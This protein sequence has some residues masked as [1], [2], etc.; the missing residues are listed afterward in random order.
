[1]DKKGGGGNTKKPPNA[2]NSKQGKNQTK[3][4]QNLDIR[5]HTQ[6]SKNDQ[7]WS[8]A[9]ETAW[10]L[11]ATH[12]HDSC[13]LKFIK[14]R[15]AKIAGLLLLLVEL[16]II[17]LTLPVLQL[18]YWSFSKSSFL[19]LVLYQHHS[20]IFSPLIRFLIQF[21]ETEV[22]SKT[23]VSYEKAFSLKG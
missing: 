22:I 17:F 11:F 13:F 15:S 7:L 14:R 9:S 5:T 2:N 12:M 1:M 6:R 20:S 10:F 4:N 16:L 19:C 21:W 23:K 8:L 18:H 3:P